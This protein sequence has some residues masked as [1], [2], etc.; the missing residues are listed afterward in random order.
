MVQLFVTVLHLFLFHFCSC[1]FDGAAI[2]DCVRAY[3]F[4]NVVQ[5][6]DSI[7]PASPPSRSHAVP[8]SGRRHC[9]MDV[10][11]NVQSHLQEGTAYAARFLEQEDYR[12]EIAALMQGL[13]G[14]PQRD[15]L[16]GSLQ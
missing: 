13:G 14:A 4:A 11:T 8:L 9:I 15:A 10:L 3:G 12:L 1:A 7:L 6:P 2:C 16:R 5:A